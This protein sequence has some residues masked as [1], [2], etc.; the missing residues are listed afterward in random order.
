[1]DDRWR[2][3][4]LLIA[5]TVGVAGLAYLARRG[6][7]VPALWLAGCL[8]IGLLGAAGLPLPVWYRFLL[9]C[10]VPLAI[11]VSVVLSSIGRGR[12]L[13]LI[14]ATFTLALG[15]KLVTLIEAP[16]SVS[17]FGS[18]LQAVW[19]LE[20]HLPP[21]PGLVATD[22]KT[23]YFIPGATGHRVLTLDKAHASSARELAYA[24]DGYR[25]L[26]RYYQGSH[27][28]WAA[29]QE[30]WRRGVRY[31]LV[32]KQTTLEPKSLADFTWQSSLLSTKVER[33]ALSRYYYANN[34]VGAL[35][36][37]SP[38]YALYRLDP[39]KLGQA[40]GTGS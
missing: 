12:V 33:K 38:E 1:V 20:K 26:R 4:L 39:R 9:L 22:P 25:L 2:W 7:A 36:Y 8:A 5:G 27:G 32:Q 30:M 16:A 19:S 37:D 34:R 31:V 14:A 6:H 17:Y 15:A 10:Q 18:D 29:G 40:S 23:A 35:L 28:W 11:G 24:E 3:P 13:A 21:G